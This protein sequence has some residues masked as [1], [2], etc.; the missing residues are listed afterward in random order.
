MADNL[1]RGV[2]KGAGRPEGGTDKE[3]ACLVCDSHLAH[4]FSSLCLSPL[5][6]GFS[7][8]PSVQYMGSLPSLS[9]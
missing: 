4:R 1:Y 2:L 6:Q 9:R 3:I 8:C 5:S 7:F